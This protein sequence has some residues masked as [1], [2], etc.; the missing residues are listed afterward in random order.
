[1]VGKVL[2]HPFEKSDIDLQKMNICITLV[3]YK[4]FVAQQVYIREVISSNGN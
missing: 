4:N 1:M 2:S 3:V